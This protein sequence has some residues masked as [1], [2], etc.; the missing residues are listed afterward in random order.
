MQ[1][2]NCTAL[3]PPNATDKNVYASFETISH[4]HIF[5]NMFGP[6]H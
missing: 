6:S 4:Q 3:I 1:I 2:I 5:V